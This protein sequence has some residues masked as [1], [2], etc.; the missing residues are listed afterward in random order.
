ML[1]DCGPDGDKLLGR[2]KPDDTGVSGKV[3]RLAFDAGCRYLLATVAGLA[4]R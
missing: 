4:C 2:T 1:V 3:Y